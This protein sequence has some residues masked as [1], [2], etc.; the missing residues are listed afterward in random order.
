VNSTSLPMI[1]LKFLDCSTDAEP[2]D[3]TTSNH[4]YIHD[5][6]LPYTLVHKDVLL[7]E[8]RIKLLVTVSKVLRDLDIAHWLIT[9]SLMGAY[10]HGV[11]MPWDDDIDLGMAPGG[12]K[13]SHKMR[14]KFNDLGV[15]VRPGSYPCKSGMYNAI[16]SYLAQVGRKANQVFMVFQLMGNP[17]AWIDVS[18]AFPVELDGVKGWNTDGTYNLMDDRSYSTMLEPLRKCKFGSHEFDCPQQSKRFLCN[19]V[20]VHLGVPGVWNND[21]RKFERKGEKWDVYDADG[22]TDFTAADTLRLTKTESGDLTIVKD[23]MVDGKLTTSPAKP[24]Q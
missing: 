5:Q 14:Q 18:E 17:N 21:T 9:G 23:S 16:C 1:A 3:L 11:T 24:N 20:G 8:L 15:T 12:I 22:T 6:R 13:K 10:R 7:W 2:K 19:Q 4:H